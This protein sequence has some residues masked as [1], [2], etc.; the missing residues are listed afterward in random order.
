[1]TSA[2]NVGALVL[3]GWV[4]VHAL[5]YDIPVAPLVPA[6]LLGYLA[7]AVPIP[8]GIGVLDAGLA[9]A[10]VIYHMPAPAAVGGV[11]LYH[12]LA[13]WIP[14]VSGTIG[15]L[16][17]H[18]QITAGFGGARRDRATIVSD[19]THAHKENHRAAHPQLA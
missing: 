7:N 14:A 11:L 18:R 16:A 13:L 9:A 17:A 2:T 4:A 6:Y 3:A 19:T 15:F 10:L 8:G 5:G 1:V 12:A